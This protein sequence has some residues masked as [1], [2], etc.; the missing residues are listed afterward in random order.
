M[1]IYEKWKNYKEILDNYK[2]FVY[3]RTGY[4]FNEYSTIYPEM[5]LL[6]STVI[7]ISSTDIRDAIQQEHFIDKWINIDVAR[8]IKENELYR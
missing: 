5:I 6:N 2:V 8:F 4:D 3:P 7:D 1:F